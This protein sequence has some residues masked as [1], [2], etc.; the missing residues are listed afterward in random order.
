VTRLVLTALL[1]AAAALTAPAAAGAAAP[2][3]A[4]ERAPYSASPHFSVAYAGSGA[5]RTDFHATP[6]NPDGDPDTNDAHDSSA[7]SW[8]LRLDR[9]L[10]VADPGDLDGAHGKTLVIGHVDH[11]HVDGLY[12]ELDR[13]VSCTLKG[14][15]G[16][17]EA[18]AAG[19]AVSHA[20]G[21]RTFS[22]TARNPLATVLTN[23]STACPDQGDSIDRI[24]DNYFTPGFS[25]APSYGPDPWFASGTVTV[26]VRVLRRAAKVVVALRPA[27]TGRPPVDC[28]V[29]NPAYEVCS[30]HGSWGGV[31]TLRRVPD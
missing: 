24:L 22:L 29:P 8:R 11:T 10:D 15:T 28:A 25:F 27:A 3:Y 20:P 19:L 1:L 21:A 2:P 31:V 17:G 5:W 30:T 4:F 13:T 16:R 9:E 14:S 18:V 7:Q 23:M 26:P 6:P 12:T